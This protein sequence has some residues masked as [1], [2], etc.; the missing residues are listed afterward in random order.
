MNSA[1]W[2]KHRSVTANL[3]ANDIQNSA[4]TDPD[5]TCSICNHLLR[6]AVKTPC[7]S[8]SFCEECI[9]NYLSENDFVCP[10]CE[11]KVKSLKMLVKDDDRRE[12]AKKYLEDTLKASKEAADKLA[13]DGDAAD[14]VSTNGEQA[15]SAGARSPNASTSGELAPAEEGELGE[16]Q[17]KPGSNGNMALNPQ[18]QQQQQMQQ[19]QQQLQML[20]NQI[21]STG[22]ILSSPTLPPQMR[23]QL[24]A[25][26]QGLQYQYGQTMQMMQSG[27]GMGMPQPMMIMQQ[28]QQMQAMQRM[29]MMQNGMQQQANNL[30]N[31]QQQFNRQFNNNRPFVNGP[32]G[33]RNGAQYDENSSESPYMR[34]PINPKFRNGG[35]KRDRPQDFLQ[36]DHPHKR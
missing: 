1:S 14:G 9:Q 34:V 23:M 2:L 16:A 13:A 33:G 15:G 28:M 25:Q 20:Q 6:D 30:Q 4:P 35:G 19:Y 21:Q 22:N 12:R 24:A 36:V 18:Q 32:H 11:S 27:N 17:A 8:K 31:Q 5:L 26:L 3:S 7:C 10:E 29:M